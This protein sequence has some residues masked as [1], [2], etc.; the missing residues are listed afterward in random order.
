MDEISGERR[1]AT[2][3]GGEQTIAVEISEYQRRPTETNGDQR[4]QFAGFYHLQHTLPVTRGEIEAGGVVAAG[5]QQYHIAF[6]H[7][8]E[9]GDHRL[10]IQLV[11]RANVRVMAN[12]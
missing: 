5:V 10:D 12:A 3:S 9:G 7:V 1:R 11:V 8:G 2:E 6:G 4:Q